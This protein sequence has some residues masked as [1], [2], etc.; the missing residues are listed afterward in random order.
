MDLSALQQEMPYQWKIQTGKK[1]GRASCVAYIDARDVMRRLDQVC[2]IGGWKD[3]YYDLAANR[4]VCAIAIKI[5]DEWVEKSDGAGST[6]IEPEKGGLS[7]AFKR[8]AVKWGIGRFLYDLPIE[9]VNTDADGKPIDKAGNRI[10][11]LTEHIN[12]QMRQPAPPA[13]TPP[14]LIIPPKVQPAAPAPRTQ[15]W[16]KE[17][18]AKIVTDDLGHEPIDHEAWKAAI[19]ERTGI[20]PMEGRF[21]EILEKL[22]AY[23]AKKAQK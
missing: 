11:D 1:G 10:Y 22:E 6:D 14:P 15:A 17:R 19:F 21:P 2:G 13:I 18:I 16:Y 3:R 20:V 5:N 7:D 9:W 4:V 8:A 23:V 12:K